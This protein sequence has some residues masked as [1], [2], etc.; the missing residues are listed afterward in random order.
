MGRI[1]VTEHMTLDGVVEDNGGVEGFERGGW[2]FRFDPGEDGRS[3]KLQEMRNSAA[4][5]LGRVTYDLFARHWPSARGELADLLNA[6]PKYVVSSTLENPGWN[7]RVLDGDPVERIAELTR[8]VQGDIVVHGS[9]QLAQTL[10]DND[11]LDELRMMVFPVV[12]GDGKRLF[13]PTRESK[14]LQLVE[15]RQLGSD[16]VLLV[17]YRPATNGEPKSAAIRRL[18]QP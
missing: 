7:T 5:L 13:G 17:T 16:G 4:L 1:I 11:L 10:I 3:F 8:E 12:L 2:Q 9:F 6:L 18:R 14:R 15:S